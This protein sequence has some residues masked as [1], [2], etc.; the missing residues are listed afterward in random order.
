[1]AAE[2]MQVHGPTRAAW[3]DPH[4]PLLDT[5]GMIGSL[6][7]SKRHACNT[8]CSAEQTDPRPGDLWQQGSGFE[9]AACTSKNRICIFADLSCV[10]CS[11]CIRKLCSACQRLSMALTTLRGMPVCACG[12]TFWR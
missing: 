11:V 12:I 8:R 3:A 6:E 2:V 5:F 1:M 4:E 9:A 10:S 7:P